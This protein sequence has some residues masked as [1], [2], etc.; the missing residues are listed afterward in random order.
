MSVLKNAKHEIFAQE[1]AK[2]GAKTLDALQKAGYAPQPAQGT[3][4]TKNVKI[5]NRIA[6][7][8][9]PGAARVAASI[10][11]I[12]QE[13]ERLS[14]SD[15]TEALEVRRNKVYLKDLKKLPKDVTAC[16]SALKSTK[17]GVEVK[18]HNKTSALELLMRHKG[19]F[20]ENINLT[21]EVS[22]LDLVNAS[23]APAAPKV[24]DHDPQE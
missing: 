15:I 3:R 22:L 12:T 24:I 16:I 2:P 1:M 21:V 11:R 13:L 10:D 17:D 8:Q 6:E 7:I 18:F 14:L 20:K 4:L 23:M 9:A 19:M 5:A